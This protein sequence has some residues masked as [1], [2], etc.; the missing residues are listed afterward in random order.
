[1]RGV[2]VDGREPRGDRRRGSSPGSA[3][4]ANVGRTIPGLAEPRDGPLVHVRR[5]RARA[6]GPAVASASSRASAPARTPSGPNGPPSS[7]RTAGSR[8]RPPAYDCARRACPA[9]AGWPPAAGKDG[10]WSSS[11]TAGRSRVEV[12]PDDTLL[13]LLR[14][15]LGLRS[16]KDGCAPEG[17]CGACTVIVDGRAV[18]SCAQSAARVGGTDVETLE[19]L[20]AATRRGWAD[21]FARGGAL[22]VRLLLARDRD[23][24][25]GAAAP[26]AG[27]LAPRRWRGPWPGTSAGAR[28]T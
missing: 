17:S 10:P 26:R 7:G 16:M 24:G 13:D 14:G 11:S 3:S 18:V 8:S 12:G 21:A 23:E 20:P 5:R 4:W 1:M 19:G 25:R 28:G 9:R 22:A 6:P 27:P 15:R 2:R